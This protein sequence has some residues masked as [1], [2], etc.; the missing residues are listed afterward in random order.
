MNVLS[1]VAQSCPTLCDPMDCSPS[2]YSVHGDSAGK[3]T[4]MGCH[5]LF[6]RVFLTQGSNPGLSNCRQI[7]YHLS[8][9]LSPRI[10]EWVAYPFSR[11]P[12]PPRNWTGVSCIA[13][14]FFTS[15]ATREAF[16]FFFFHFSEEWYLHL[17]S[18]FCCIICFILLALCWFI[19][20]T[21]KPSGL[22]QQ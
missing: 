17:L 21:P 16:F 14:R 2:G 6:Q 4:G 3:N 5:A 8:H 12:S 13:G 1:L 10:L 18:F 11:G 15:W 19:T 20:I 22:W 7:L 9:Q